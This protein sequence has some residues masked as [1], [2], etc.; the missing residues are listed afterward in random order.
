MCLAVPGKVIEVE[1]DDPLLRSARV[2]FSGVIKEVSLACAPEAQLGDYVLV[3]VG[4]AISVIDQ[5]EAEETFRYLKQMG[6]LD[7]L[8][9]ETASP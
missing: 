7:D 5:Q 9:E 6:E 2:S 3:H 4:L 1:G 8:E